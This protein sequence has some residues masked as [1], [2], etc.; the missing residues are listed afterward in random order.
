MEKIFFP[1]D[2]NSPQ[3]QKLTIPN[4]ESL[5]CEFESLLRWVVF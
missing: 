3:G 5:I 1:V 2:R 4:F